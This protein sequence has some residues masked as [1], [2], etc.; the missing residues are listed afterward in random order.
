MARRNGIRSTAWPTNKQV[1]YQ[2]GFYFI[3]IED[4]FQINEE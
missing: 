2:F 3:P 4:E 1:Q